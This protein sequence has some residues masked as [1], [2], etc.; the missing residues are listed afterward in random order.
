MYLLGTQESSITSS[1]FQGNDATEGNTIT[2]LFADALISNI[3]IKDNTAMIQSTG[4]FI[5]FS[6]VTV[7][8]STFR[9]DA[10]PNGAKTA[11]EVLFDKSLTGGFTC[12]SAGST[13]TFTRCSFVNGYAI[14]GGSVYL[15][16]NSAVTFESCIFI[17]S[18]ASY[19][20]G[21][22]YASDF[23]SLYMNS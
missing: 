18:Y 2:L 7:S 9:T 10:Y 6:K 13:V 16:G 23:K 8:D 20:G 12:I 21:A 22:I 14:S 5:T 3:V 17:N 4:I 19:T 1:T 11:K 15:S